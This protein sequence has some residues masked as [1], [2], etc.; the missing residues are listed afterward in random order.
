[1]SFTE[2]GITLDMKIHL[3]VP[4]VAVFLALASTSSAQ[5]VGGDTRTVRILDGPQNGAHFG[6]FMANAGDIDADGVQ[7]LIVAAPQNTPNGMDRAGSAM[8]Y[9]GAT[10]ALLFQVDGTRQLE[11]F[12]SSVAGAG[13][14]NGDGHDDFLVGNPGF[15]HPGFAAL[16][17]VDLYSGAD[18]SLLR[19][20][21]GIGGVRFLGE[22]CTGIGDIDGDGLGD[23]LLGSEDSGTVGLNQHGRAYVYSGATDTLLYSIEGTVAF[24]RLGN[25]VAAAGDFNADGTPDF[26]LGGYAD[27]IAT[28]VALVISGASGLELA[29]FDGTNPSDLL[30]YSMA[31]VGDCNGDGFDDVLIGS[32]FF[33]FNGANSSGSAFLYSGFDSS[34]LFRL[35]G[36]DAYDS[37]ASSIASTGD[38]NEDGHPDFII[39]AENVRAGGILGA[40]RAYV[41]S[42]LDAT[43]LFTIDG[44]VN[45]DRMGSSV[46]GLGDVDGDFIPDVAA[47]AWSVDLGGGFEVGQVTLL[48]VD[49]YLSLD[50]RRVSLT[51]GAT[52][53][54]ELDFPDSN[55]GLAYR[56]LLSKSGFGPVT[57]GVDIPLTQDL[58]FNHSTQGNYP[59]PHTGLFGTL[60]SSGNASAS[61]DILPGSF[62]GGLG[63][64]FRLAAVAFPTG[65]L[66]TVSSVSVPVVL[67]P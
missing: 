3:P 36:I 24:E 6:E 7:D 8:V 62:P 20:H 64:T 52:V 42:G 35:D 30:S 11:A 57:F 43:E 10:G 9:S 39:G 44:Q 21:E 48:G 32:P 13:D 40:G 49:P 67:I 33:D 18:G 17:S 27:V 59:F 55:A 15:A 54:V 58:L 4:R 41:Y 63:T 25:T 53:I 51:T 50:R 26:L 66:P 16:G 14:T 31:G 38:I 23:I 29:R 22:S 37:F 2:L 46:V 12:A 45:S 47:G 65:L 5:M 34:I 28:G 19:R 61:L 56:V 60:D 1:M